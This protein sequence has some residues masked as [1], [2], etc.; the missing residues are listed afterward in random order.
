MR[1][2][3][4]RHLAGKKVQLRPCVF[5]IKCQKT[6][7]ALITAGFKAQVQISI[8]YATNEIATP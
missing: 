7:H 3:K 1:L 5:Q 8:T 6:F 4:A 2:M